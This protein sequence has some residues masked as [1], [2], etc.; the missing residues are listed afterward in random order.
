MT[1]VRVTLKLAEPLIRLKALMLMSPAT[2]ASSPLSARPEPM[3][4]FQSMAVAPVPDS[5]FNCTT[6]LDTEPLMPGMPV[7]LALSD[8]PSRPNQLLLLDGSDSEANLIAALVTVMPKPAVPR[9]SDCEPLTVIEPA[10]SGAFDSP[11]VMTV[12]RVRLTLKLAEP[13]T[14]LKALMLTSPATEASSP[15]RVRPEPVTPLQLIADAPVPD[16]VLS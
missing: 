6:P 8:S 4:P 9:V 3:T 2:E 1:R 12:T 11:G 5:V 14:R 15:L 7:R 10:S 13:L 16:S